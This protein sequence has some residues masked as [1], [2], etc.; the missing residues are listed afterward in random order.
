VRLSST[1]SAHIHSDKDEVVK[2]AAASGEG[3]RNS[4]DDD[5]T[6]SERSFFSKS[7]RPPASTRKESVIHDLQVASFVEVSVVSA[8]L[9]NPPSFCL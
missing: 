6:D 9:T 1:S 7:G 3:S 5:G 2:V 8:M 4:S